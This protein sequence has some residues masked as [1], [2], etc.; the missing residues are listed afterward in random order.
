[1]TRALLILNNKKFDKYSYFKSKRN[2]VICSTNITENMKSE[3]VEKILKHDIIIIGGGPQH[4][5]NDKI[6]NHTEVIFLKIV[7]KICEN[8]INY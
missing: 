8:T 6:D 5:T 2:S 4:L 3:I 1:M 7:V